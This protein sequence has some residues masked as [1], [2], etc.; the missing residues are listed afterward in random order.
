MRKYLCPLLALLTLA[1]AGCGDSAPS[2]KEYVAD[3]DAIC[4]KSKEKIEKIDP[5]QSVPQIPRFVR[6][7][8]VVVDDSIEE[9]E[10]LE[11]PE[12]GR[13]GFE[14]YISESKKSLSAF[15][16]LEK[17]AEENDRS[18]VRRIF[19]ETLAENKKRDAQAERLGLKE[20]G[21]G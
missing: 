10:K 11:L 18:A 13:K 5:P 4:K 2:K 6:E 16:E 1:A 9:A 19:N 21:S 8:R 3:L 17:A 20:C 15:D 12:E 7:S 14:N